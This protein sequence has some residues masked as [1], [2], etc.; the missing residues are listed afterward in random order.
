MHYVF[1]KKCNVALYLKKKYKPRS[2][3]KIKNN[4]ADTRGSMQTHTRHL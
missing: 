2:E 3:K 4:T 1:L